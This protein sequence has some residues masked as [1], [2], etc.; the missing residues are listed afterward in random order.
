MVLRSQIRTPVVHTGVWRG[1]RRGHPTLR[2]AGGQMGGGVLPFIAAVATV[3]LS[4]TLPPTHSMTR[5]N[6]ISSRSFTAIHLL[7]FTASAFFFAGL[8]RAGNKC[9]EKTCLRFL[10]R[11]V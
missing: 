8:I 10:H 4:A 9:D 7:C 3:E 11:C 5:Y 6:S 1:S 2:L